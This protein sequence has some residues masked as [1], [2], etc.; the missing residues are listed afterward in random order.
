MF[1]AGYEKPFLYAYLY[2]RIVDSRSRL[3]PSVTYLNTS[4][5]AFYLIPAIVKRIRRPSQPGA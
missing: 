1:D 2:M 4:A 3:G 5:F